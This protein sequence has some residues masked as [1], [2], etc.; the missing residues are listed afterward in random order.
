MER[1]RNLFYGKGTRREMTNGQHTTSALDDYFEK[2]E[3]S[4]KRKAELRDVYDQL[5]KSLLKKAL[6]GDLATVSAVTTL[7]VNKAKLENYI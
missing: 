3:Q 1:I 2:S 5:I 7:L 6:E 4:S